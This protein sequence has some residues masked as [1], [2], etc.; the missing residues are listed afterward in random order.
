MKSFKEKLKTK[1]KTLKIFENNSKKSRPY[2]ISKK[3][4]INAIEK[5]ENCT[6]LINFENKNY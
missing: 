1:E 6:L 5:S 3:K 2:Q 4:S